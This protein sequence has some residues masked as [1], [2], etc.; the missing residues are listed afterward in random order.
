MSTIIY[1]FRSQN[2]AKIWQG[3]LT[4]LSFGG[5]RFRIS[6]NEDPGISLKYL[7]KRGA[8]LLLW[9]PDLSREKLIAAEMCGYVRGFERR[10]L[11]KNF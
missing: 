10:Q 8:Q 4:R 11:G 7:S 6:K 3:R 5:S 1:H 9:L 2:E